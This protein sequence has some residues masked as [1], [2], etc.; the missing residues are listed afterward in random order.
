MTDL[1]IQIRPLNINENRFLI[2][3]SYQA[4]F[5]PDGEPPPSKDIVDTPQLEK[6]FKEWGRT[7]DHCLVAEYEGEKI[8]AIW[9]R[10]F[11]ASNKSFGYVSDDI[12]E[13]S[14]AVDKPYRNKGVG[15]MLIEAFYTHL[16]ENGFH[17]L[18]LSVDRCNPAV[19]LYL[20]TGFNII[21]T[22]VNDYLML[23]QL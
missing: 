21:R 14:I 1:N 4:I 16:N 18:S 22:N 12:P 20:R 10:L 7:G 2:D 5:I 15:T 8:G 6:Y 11:D 17:V 13:L 23:K 19:N 3:M 9:C